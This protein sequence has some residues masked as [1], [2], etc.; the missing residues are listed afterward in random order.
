MLRFISLMLLSMPLF[1]VS[2]TPAHPVIN[3]DAYL[4]MDFDTGR[5]LIEHNIDQRLP[6]AS[7]TKL[8]T[9]YIL[10][11][12]VKHGRIS[13]DD[14]VTVSRNAWS[15]NPIFRGSSLMWIEPGKPVTVRDLEKGIVISSG[16]D[17]TVAIAEHIS[18]SEESFVELMNDYAT[19]F[20]LSGT[21]Y[22]NTHGLPHIGHLT[23]A[24]D[25]ATLAAMVIRSHPDHYGVYK[26]KSYTYNDITQYNRN[27]LLN[28]DPSIDGLKTGYTRESGYGLVAS[29][30]RESM[31]LISVVLGS[32]DS[33]TR[34]S[35][36]RAL[37]NYGFRF[38]QT[39]KPI[40]PEVS[41]GQARVW[42]GES[43]LLDGGVLESV[44]AT[45]PRSNT[46]FEVVTDFNEPLIAPISRGDI[47]GN[48]SVVFDGEVVSEQPLQALNDIPQAG[49]FARLWD[50]FTLWLTRLLE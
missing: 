29:A 45:I 31:R 12:E 13:L 18:G 47:V 40:E 49:F 44:V 27:L 15:Q 35:E 20:G 22:E 9:A 23:T 21:H 39:I 14:Q 48:V 24:R 30:K 34:K 36:S 16:N 2:L 17:A 19:E 3:A 7:L 50:G 26:Q 4:V 32:A 41:L 28:E 10:A 43:N 1:A 5:I 42:K 37:L 46:T 33:R 8:M 11:E 38:Y 25:L 6:P